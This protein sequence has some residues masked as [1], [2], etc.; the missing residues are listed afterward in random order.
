MAVSEPQTVMIQLPADQLRLFEDEGRDVESC[1]RQ[2]LGNEL[3]WREEGKQRELFRRYSSAV[4]HFFRRRGLGQRESWF[5]THETFWRFY[6]AMERHG[7][8]EKVEVGL[9]REMCRVYDEWARGAQRFRLS[10][11]ATAAIP[12]QARLR[13]AMQGILQNLPPDTRRCFHL[14]ARGIEETEMAELMGLTRVDVGDHLRQARRRITESLLDRGFPYEAYELWSSGETLVE[15]DESLRQ[16][17]LE[18]LCQGW[19]TR[20]LLPAESVPLALHRDIQ[21]MLPRS[22]EGFC[23]SLEDLGVRGG[24]A[25]PQEALREGVERARSETAWLHRRLTHT[26]TAE[27]RLRKRTLL[28]LVDLTSSG[29]LERGG[30]YT[31]V[32]G[33]ILR[34]PRGDLAF[35]AADNRHTMYPLVQSVAARARPDDRLRFARVRAGEAGEPV[36]PVEEIEEPPDTP[37]EFLWEEWRRKVGGD[38]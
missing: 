12:G 8:D 3:E 28:G 27:Q 11:P 30:D 31:W 14:M 29:L 20:Y 9:A 37:S 19:R 24:G 18:G 23:C 32:V 36:G 25:T 35:E 38:A 34:D 1:I 22:G 17:L 2:A 5:L 33:R 26:L 16:R 4:L 13:D 6:K 15:S 7:P 21:V 10:S